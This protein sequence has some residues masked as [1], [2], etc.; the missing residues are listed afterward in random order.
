MTTAAVN[1]MESLR[2]L[3]A[4]IAF[5]DQGTD[6]VFRTDAWCRQVQV[7]TE[8][9]L[10]LADGRSAQV[11]ARSPQGDEVSLSAQST[12]TGS[13][14]WLHLEEVSGDAALEQ[15]RGRIAE[16][17]QHAHKDALTGLWNRRFFDSAVLVEMARSDRHRCPL[18]LL[19]IDVD[20]FKA[21][22]DRHGHTVGDA[23]LRKIAQ[24]LLGRCRRGDLVTRWGGDEFAILATFCSWRDGLTLAQSLLHEVSHVDLAPGVRTTLS[25]GVGQYLPGEATESWF[26]RVDAQVYAAKRSGRDAA[27]ANTG[28]P[29]AADAGA[30]QLI[31]RDQYLSGHPKIDSQHRTLIELANRVLVAALA[32]PESRP[33]GAKLLTSLD[34]LL[35]HLTQHFANE[36]EILAQVGYPRLRQHQ[37]AHAHLLAKATELRAL[38]VAGEASLGTLVDFLA[39]EVAVGHMATADVDF[40]GWVQPTS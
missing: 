29:P 19:V 1:W 6:I 35:E 24:L 17:E 12:Q 22:N 5:C 31:W 39:R 40:Y 23:V 28:S 38:A 36:E 21:I 26:E 20:H 15:L 37:L 11:L 13:G 7:A 30:L 16:L 3:P 25:I 32:G 9:V 14:M 8:R 33:V 34:A 4:A 18:T 27:R 10:L 2:S